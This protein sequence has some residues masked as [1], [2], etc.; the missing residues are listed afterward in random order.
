M[1]MPGMRARV[2]ASCG[3]ATSADVS[4]V[5]LWSRSL[6]QIRPEHLRPEIPEERV[7][8]SIDTDVEGVYTSDVRPVAGLV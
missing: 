3:A 6:Y 5:C 2:D 4:D 7:C 8:L 1:T